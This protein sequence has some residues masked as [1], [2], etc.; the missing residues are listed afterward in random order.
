MNYMS[1]IAE[2][3]GVEMGEKFW[4]GWT[5]RSKREPRVVIN[6]SAFGGNTEYMLSDKGIQSC[7]TDESGNIVRTEYPDA[8]LCWLLTGRYFIIK[9][10]WKPKIGEM[11]FCVG[12]SGNIN[13]TT[14]DE[15][16]V[17][18]M[19]Y[20]AGNCYRTK[21]DAETHKDEILAKMKELMGE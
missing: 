13:C 9:K 14:W 12:V 4:M 8:C 2:M 17:D 19:H 16:T 6:Q 18:I 10:Q 20:L 11:Y 21:K 5:E 7:M 3:L 1:K 15:H